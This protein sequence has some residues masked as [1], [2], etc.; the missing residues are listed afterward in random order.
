MEAIHS[1]TADMQASV[2]QILNE[3]D[4]MPA[5]LIQWVPGPEVWTVMQNLCHIEEFV[6]YWT[7]QI[8]QIIAHP[9]QEWGRTHHD[10]GRLA[11]VANSTARDLG[12]VKQN[13]Q[14]H[15]SE[16]V[17]R[18]EAISAAQFAMEAPSRNPRWGVK[19]ASFIVDTL[20]V[21]HLRSHLGQIR[22][23]VAQ[24]KSFAR[25]NSKGEQA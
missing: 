18:L 23:N 7:G 14:Q 2:A 12:E 5:E 24:Y 16:S 25:N 10:E 15:V 1:A 22:R 20:L 11:A 13:I 6:P 4:A 9:E 21:T 17:E 8:E 3:V 19:P